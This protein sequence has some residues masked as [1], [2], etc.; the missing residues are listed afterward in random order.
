MSANV[1][2]GAK[3]DINAEGKLGLNCWWEGTEFGNR[4]IL[5]GDADGEIHCREK[6]EE[7][8]DT[9]KWVGEDVVEHCGQR[10]FVFWSMKTTTA[11]RPTLSRR[12]ERERKQRKHGLRREGE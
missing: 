11:T 6:Y 5:E 1:P 10:V 2:K 7:E 8:D 9:Q 4:P 3:E 12:R